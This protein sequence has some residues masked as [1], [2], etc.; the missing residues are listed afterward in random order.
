MKSNI[1]V[2]VF[3]TFFALILFEFGLRCVGTFLTHSEKNTEG[4]LYFSIRKNEQLDSWF[5]VHLPHDT[6][7]FKKPEFTFHRVTN[8]LGLSD[9]EWTKQDSSFVILGIGDSFTEGT[10]VE[11]D[12]TWLKVLEANLNKKTEY[13]VSTMNAGVGG[14]DPVFEYLLLEK[15]LMAYNPDMV[16]LSINGSD[17]HEITL[18]GGFERFKDDGTTGRPAPK[19]EPFYQYSHVVRFVV[20]VLLGFHEDLITR[21]EATKNRKRFIR[22]METIN[23]KIDSLSRQNGFEYLLVVHPIGYDFQSN[24]YA[25]DELN[26]LVELLDNSQSPFL[27]IRKCLAK[28]GYLTKEDVEPIYWPIDKHFNMKGYELYAKYV[29]SKIESEF[30]KTDSLNTTQK[31]SQP[32]HAIP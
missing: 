21:S 15:K 2:S 14:S 13:P 1:L 31:D 8:S 24:R 28:D 22:I 16:I 30:L 9:I 18:R 5:W 29:A 4:G 26:E 20:H 17:I 10:G 11:A 19:W 7:I 3:A 23:T 12:A 32:S 6:L 25:Y 27:D